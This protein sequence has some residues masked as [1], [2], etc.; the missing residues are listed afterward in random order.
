MNTRR[1]SLCPGL[2]NPWMALFALS[3]TLACGGGTSSRD[4]TI[5][6]APDVGEHVEAWVA[7]WNSYDLDRVDELFLTDDTVTYFSSEKE[8]LIRGIDAVREHH[9]SFGFV[10]GGKAA[11][12]ELWLEDLH[13]HVYGSAAVVTAIWYFGNRSDDGDKVQRGPMT[14]VYV[15]QRDDY[16]L[17]HLHFAR[18]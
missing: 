13:S 2:G 12:N 17:A 1:L 8:G 4:D 7:F 16:R 9:R 15:R 11:E 18:Y 5:T 3:T 14:L 10:E 6:S